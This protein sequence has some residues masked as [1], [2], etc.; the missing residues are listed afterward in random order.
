MSIF[1][2]QELTSIQ[3]SLEETQAESNYVASR[4]DETFLRLDQL[5]EHTERVYE[6]MVN[7]A[8]T[9]QN[10][11]TKQKQA[12]IVAEV[13]HLSRIF[14]SE[15]SMFL[16]G[17]QAL[18]NNQFSPLLVEPERLQNAYDEIVDR[19][20]EVNLAPLTEDADLIFQSEVSVLGTQNDDLICI[21]HV[22]LYSGELMNLF[23]YV[24]APFLLQDG[25]TATTRSEKSYLALD[26]SGTL[27]KE[28]SEAEVSRCKRINRIY[29]CRN[30]NVLQKNLSQL[31]LFNLYKQRMSEIEKFCD[32]SVAEV[33]SHAVQLSGNQFQIMTSRPTQLTIACEEGAEV[34]TIQ[35]VHLLTLTEDCPKANTP[36]HFFVRNPH[37][38]SSQQLIPLPL[39]QDAKEWIKEINATN[40]DVSLNEIFKE[41]KMDY[42][43]HV[44]I[45]KFKHRIVN[46]RII[47][48][49]SWLTYLQLAMT[50]LG[51]IIITY[52]TVSVC[53][54][55]GL[56]LI[57]RLIP[58]LMRRKKDRVREYRIVRQPRQNI[59]LRQRI[60]PSAPPLS[61]NL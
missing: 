60:C 33:A 32:V 57:R 10:L 31:C 13:D 61:S 26:P 11:H 53:I 2:R 18:L 52:K 19:A 56:P 4:V 22:P 43:G 40:E 54:S 20:K 17:L 16:T 58:N 39:I 36:D 27:G 3:K 8:K 41:L 30:E 28:L 42:S 1:N 15:T 35:G 34:E 44:P 6:A 51:V 7:I 23:R 29:H 37:V 25:L 48:Y 21:I 12:M 38:V 14:V 45:D 50:M 59:E 9:N 24:P 47:K 49:R 46:R 55:S 5:I